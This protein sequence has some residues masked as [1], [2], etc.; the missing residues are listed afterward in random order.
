MIISTNNNDILKSNEKIIAFPVNV[1]GFND[2]GISYEIL[3]KY[4]RNMIHSKEYKLGTV[5]PKNVNNI[6]LYA[7]VCY[8]IKDGW[9]NQREIIKEC[10]DKIKTNKPIATVEMGVQFLDKIEGADFNEIVLGMNDSKQEIILYS[11]YSLEHILKI[12]DEDKA[13][14]KKKI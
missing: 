1:E 8:S 14:V 5:I 13:K 10:F 12:C 2:A 6:F 7:L 4:W 11:N 9:I 3:K